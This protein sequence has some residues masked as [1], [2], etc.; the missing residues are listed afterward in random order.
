M[1]RNRTTTASSATALA[2]QYLHRGH[3]QPPF[4]SASAG[5]VGLGMA[6]AGR[7]GRRRTIQK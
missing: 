4:E 5:A 6:A 2:P 7:N 3:E 1:L